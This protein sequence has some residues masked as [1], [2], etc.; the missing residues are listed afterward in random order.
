MIA[1]NK[2]TEREAINQYQQ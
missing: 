2:I 1:K